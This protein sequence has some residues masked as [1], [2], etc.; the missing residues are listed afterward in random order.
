MQS[1]RCH[2]VCQ[3]TPGQSPGLGSLS[4]TKQTHGFC[5]LFCLTLR[6]LRSH[7]S[8]HLTGGA[9]VVGTEN[10]LGGFAPVYCVL[11]AFSAQTLC[12]SIYV[13]RVN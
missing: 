4:S 11:H 10:W 7:V 12:A 8:N 13:K 6:L 9:H 2:G 3:H 5:L 1:V